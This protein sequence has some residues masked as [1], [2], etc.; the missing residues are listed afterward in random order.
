M[1]FLSVG[2]LQRLKETAVQR[3]KAMCEG[4][5]APPENSFVLICTFDWAC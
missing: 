5:A 2:G 1:Y 3:L 4:Q